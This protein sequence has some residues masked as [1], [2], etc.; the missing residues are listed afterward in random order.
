MTQTGMPQR[1]RTR[2]QVLLTAAEA[3]PALERAF[4]EA[5]TEIRGSFRIF[6]PTT[7]LRSPEA[8]AVGE[9]WFDLILH[10][11]RR[12]VAI[13]LVISDFD[14]IARAALH[15]GTWKSVRM[16]RAAAELAG[17]E[18]RLSVT[19][20]MHAAETGVVPRLLFWPQIMKKLTRSAGW[21]NRLPPEEQEAALRD[22]PGLAERLWRA[23]NGRYRPRLA[24]LPR[25]FPATHH[26]KLAVFDRRKLYIGGLDL[27]ERRYD[28]PEHDRPGAETWHDVQLMMEGPVV[29]EAQ[30]HLENFLAVVEGKQ[31]PGPQRRLLRTLSRRRR[32][33]APFFGPEPV[34]HEIATAHAALARR[35]DRLIYIETQ[36][37]RDRHLAHLLAGLA[38]EK[39]E[40]QM[41][42]IL[43]AAP[44]DVAFEGRDG[45][46]ARYGEYLQ[47][48]ALR[49]LRRGFGSRLFVGGA[50]QPRAQRKTGGHDRDRLNG[51]A[52]IYVHAKVSVFDEDAAIVSSANLNGRSLKWDT[53][54]GVYLNTAREVAELRRRVMAHWL[55][56]DAGHA[57]FD[58]TTALQSWSRL[59]W[60]NAALPP[61]ERQGFILP[62]DMK[63]AAQFGRA[64]P[65]VPPEMM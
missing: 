46:D 29:A 61:A 52:I 19:P 65:G 53:E 25:L 7:L 49:I 33:E 30:A 43:P 23:P 27:D 17:P 15:R 63:A 39:P 4:L 58:Q 8:Q 14:P 48:R 21:L 57:F 54:A 3:F 42:L 55:P 2:V 64:L 60:Q 26:Q 6:D 38:R 47:A 18:A 40:L 41:I 28:T 20:A 62:Y 9:T 11:L 12:G 36:F 32:F 16:L 34:V 44:E 22:M 56:T 10:T 24:H 51:A 5:R 1:P 45:M 50:A 13:T 31:P 37:F 35:T 59:A